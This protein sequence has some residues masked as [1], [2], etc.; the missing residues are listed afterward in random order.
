MSSR[1][2]G[3]HGS[4]EQR[5]QLVPVLLK[6]PGE[7]ITRAVVQLHE[8][9]KQTMWR[10]LYSG[11]EAAASPCSSPSRRTGQKTPFP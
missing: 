11:H 3:Q 9:D 5:D 10:Q 7:T 6:T 8:F 2:S 1:P 4:L